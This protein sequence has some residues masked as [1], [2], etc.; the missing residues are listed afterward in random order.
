VDSSC[1]AIR[2]HSSSGIAAAQTVSL[3]VAR[4]APPVFCLESRERTS[5]LAVR[6]RLVPIWIL[7][8]SWSPPVSNRR[9]ADYE[10]P[11][12]FRRSVS[13]RPVPVLDHT[14]ATSSSLSIP[15][16]LLV[17]VCDAPHRS[18][19]SS[20]SVV[21]SAAYH[22]FIN[23]VDEFLV[24]DGSSGSPGFGFGQFWVMRDGRSGNTG[25][26]GNEGSATYRLQTRPKGS[27]PTL[28]A[29]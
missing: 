6:P 1:F 22:A 3:I 2:S 15:G 24:R 16:A 18:V 5:R 7:M 21:A 12:I 8:I 19:K 10:S 27:N 20:N 28:T 29:I 4:S 11:Y 17:G 26:S 13:K 9:P 25:A 14:N 23:P